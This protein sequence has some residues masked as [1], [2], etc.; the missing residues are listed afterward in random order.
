MRKIKN[1]IVIII[2][3]IIIII[4]K[5][6]FQ[7]RDYSRSNQI[8]INGKII[9][10]LIAKTKTEITRGLGGR[11]FLDNNSGMLFIMPKH[12]KYTFW[13]KD[14]QFPIDII[15]ISDHQIVDITK[16]IPVEKN[17]S[18]TLYQPK[19]EAN[20]VLE[21]NS[22]YTDLYKIKIGDSVNGINKIY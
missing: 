19:K 5:N 9:H 22:G 18:L 8:S 4:I 3:I 10:I 1:I 21:V 16:N 12:D 14:M 7:N 13:M 15:W 17:G 6:A 2:I 11:E 20:Y